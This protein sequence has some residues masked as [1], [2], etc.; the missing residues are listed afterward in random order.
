[1]SDVQLPPW[2]EAVPEG[3]R[4]QAIQRYNDD[5]ARKKERQ[6]MVEKEREVR[7]AVRLR[8][9][10]A[11]KDCDIRL[12]YLD[13]AGFM[14]VIGY[15]LDEFDA[16]RG[17]SVYKCVFSVCSRSDRAVF[18]KIKSRSLILERFLDLKMK[19]NKYEFFCALSGNPRSVASFI[20]ERFMEFVAGKP[21]GLPYDLIC[22]VRDE[23][24]GS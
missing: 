13:Y 7:R 18:S 22:E 23:I 5:L 15:R 24:Y 20:Q 17:F 8:V 21:E 12:V 10:D 11:L 3:E 14:I 6:D 9:S 1:M 2:V 19:G 4:E 16:R